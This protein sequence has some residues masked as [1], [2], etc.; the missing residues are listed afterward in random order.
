MALEVITKIMES[1]I[2][3]T[4]YPKKKKNYGRNVV[5]PVISLRNTDYKRSELA[6]N[7]PFT[8]QKHNR[9]M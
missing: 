4:V 8:I 7:I 9:Q 1:Y 2:T 3:F 6:Q 5:Y